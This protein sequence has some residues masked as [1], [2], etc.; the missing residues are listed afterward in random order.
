[1]DN[2]ASPQKWNNHGSMRKIASMA[3]QNC[4]STQQQQD[5]LMADLA[6][7]LA[8]HQTAFIRSTLENK[9]RAWR[10]YSEYCKSCVLGNNPFL[11]GM[12][13]NKKIEIMGAFAVAVR[14]GQFSGPHHASLSESSISST[15][16]LVAASFRENGR[17]NLT[18][19]AE[20]N[21]ARLLQWELRS[22]KKDD[23]KKRQQKALPVCV[24]CLILSLKATE[25]QQ[26]L[27][28]LAG[29]AYFWAIRSSEYSKVTK[30]KQR[31]IKQLCL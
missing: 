20:R 13:R 18:R 1:M 16:D 14:Q 22:H 5:Y 23:P 25:L 27:G 26:A 3:L 24:L 29:A 4:T 21:F 17:D 31:Q 10:R 12:S 28:E 15:L 30:A 8:A 7:A 6:S 2:H 19:D 11:K 9:A